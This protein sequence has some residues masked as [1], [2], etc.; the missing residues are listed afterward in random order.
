MSNGNGEDRIEVTAEQFEVITA[1][2]GI[3]A[4]DWFRSK[5][6]QYVMDRIAMEEEKL[7]EDLI[8]AA[9]KSPDAKVVKIALD[10]NM[11]RT[12]PKY[13]NEAIQAG[14]NAEKNLDAMAAAEDEY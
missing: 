7:I 14:S 11:H 1:M 5:A 2:T 12:L 10:I 4:V 3:E 9:L 6:G 8:E 13:L